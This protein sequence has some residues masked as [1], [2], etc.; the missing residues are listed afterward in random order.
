M[1]DDSLLIHRLH[2]PA[3][4]PSRVQALIRFRNGALIGIRAGALVGAMLVGALLSAGCVLPPKEAPHPQA[5]DA[6]RVG[7]AGAAVAPSADDWWSS[8]EDPQLD[9]LIRRGLENSPTLAQARAR[10]GAAVAQSDAAHSRLLPSASLD[11]SA[12]YQRAPQ[13]YV[14]PPP[15]AGH[16]FWMEQAGASLGWDLDFWGRQADAVRGSRDLAAAAQLDED[17][18]RLMLAGAIAHAYIDLYR[19]NALAD[20]AVRSQAQRQNILEI[21][22][23]RVKA[24]LDT[25]LEVRQAEGQLPQARVARE[26]AQAAADLAVHQLATLTGQGADGYASIRPPS[27]RVDAALPVPTELPINLLARRPDVQSA[28]MTV[29]AADAQRR[30][31]KA[32][33]YPDVNLHALA[34]VAAFGMSNL[35]QWSARG[36]GAGPFISLPLFDG[37]KLRADYR[38]REAQLDSAI[39][40]YDDTVLHAVQQTADQITGLDAL[41][42]ERV[43]QQQTL[44][45]NEAA[46]K[47]AEERYRAGLASYLTV[48]NAETQV[49]G[50]RQNMV[51]IL[52]SQAAARVTL[53]L[54]V[55]GS[56]DP[57]PAA[58]V[59]QARDA[60]AARH[61]PYSGN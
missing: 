32:A 13:E 28:R 29:D 23:R 30:A 27:M 52:S 4:R 14:I 2:G 42:R 61:T 21:T 33:F 48:L 8:F 57:R 54:A 38:G 19:Q 49:L 60:D 7:L 20:I 3:Q 59:A 36:Y 5:L 40:G 6:G 53:L 44:E 43:D 1:I 10:V 37:G 45:A 31:A 24:G 55:G 11:A 39:A 18:A 41:A 15:L 56:F 58:A 50:A 17:D 47:L 26:Q 25:Q 35:V 22:R 51:D 12:L 9:G 16:T 46:Y 34:G